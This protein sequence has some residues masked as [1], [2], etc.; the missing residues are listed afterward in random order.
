[1]CSSRRTRNSKIGPVY[2][3]SAL[4]AEAIVKSCA[5]R[6]DEGKRGGEKGRRAVF[7]DVRIAAATLFQD[8]AVR[9]VMQTEKG[10]KPIWLD[11]YPALLERHPDLKTE[12]RLRTA[13]SCI[14]GG[15][16]LHARPSRHG[17]SYTFADK[18]TCLDI[19]TNCKSRRH[20]FRLMEAIEYGLVPAV[21]LHNLRFWARENSGPVEPGSTQ[22]AI[23]SGV[24][25]EG[26]RIAYRPA[27]PRRVFAS[28]QVHVTVAGL[29]KA[30]RYLSTHAIEDALEVLV[31][32]K[33]IRRV[34]FP[35]NKRQR[36][37]G[38]VI[39]YEFVRPRD[40]RGYEAHQYQ[41]DSETVYDGFNSPEKQ[42]RPA[43]ALAGKSQSIDNKPVEKVDSSNVTPHSPKVTPNSSN[44]TPSNSVKDFAGNELDQKSKCLI[45]DHYNPPLPPSAS[46]SDYSRRTLVEGPL[47]VTGTSS[48]SPPPSSGD[49]TSSCI[50]IALDLKKRSHRP[51]VDKKPKKMARP[52]NEHLAWLANMHPDERVLVE[53]HHR[54]SGEWLD[55]KDLEDW[56]ILTNNPVRP[57]VRAIKQEASP[58]RREAPMPVPA[59]DQDQQPDNGAGDL[60]IVEGRKMPMSRPIQNLNHK[61]NGHQFPP[62]EF[63]Q[64]GPMTEIMAKKQQN[65][66][67]LSAH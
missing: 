7:S 52:S 13:L 44:V 59:N 37:S 25:K 35:A 12:N 41:R 58:A 47:V 16:L 3:F 5:C 26:K 60:E 24:T 63:F 65:N 64:T 40:A 56:A 1:M 46:P 55:P 28:G 32:A 29:R 38:R 51:I 27:R 4:L 67:A 49:N 61:T 36:K 45:E 10:R 21:I 6:D 2:T 23:I 39:I 34:P 11:S 50:A 62:E 20:K 42:A 33:I 22:P 53:A 57:S 18:D 9:I 8:I 30:C 66:A 15:K 19:L 48:A 17:T 14:I 43:Y 54:K 31:N